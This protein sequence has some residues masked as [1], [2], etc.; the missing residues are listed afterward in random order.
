MKGRW[1]ILGTLIGFLLALSIAWTW[2]RPTVMGGAGPAAAWSWED[3]QAMDASPGMQRM[4]E[5]MPA[6]LQA[7]CDEMHAQMGSMMTGSGQMS[8]G[9]MG[10]GMMGS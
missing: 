5:R 7:R 4:H 1:L 9:M 3:M 10:P 8:P 6:G 2:A